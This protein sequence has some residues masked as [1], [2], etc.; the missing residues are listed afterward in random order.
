MRNEEI[1]HPDVSNV[2]HRDGIANSQNA[3]S[4]FAPKE[5]EHKAI[6]G[7]VQVLVV[8]VELNPG[9]IN[10]WR[11][12]AS[13]TNRHNKDS[14]DLWAEIRIGSELKIIGNWKE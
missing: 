12:D 13:S 10:P 3:K 4:F 11:Y 7:D 1:S 8:P 14:Y 2:F 9:E 6:Q 5:S